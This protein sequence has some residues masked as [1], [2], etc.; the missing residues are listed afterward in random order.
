MKKQIGYTVISSDGSWYLRD[1]DNPDER[2]VFNTREEAEENKAML[3][4]NLKM[5]FLVREV[6]V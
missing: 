6:E 1:D 5:D 2:A 4:R 3:E